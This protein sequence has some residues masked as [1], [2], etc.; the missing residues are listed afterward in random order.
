M[1]IR[2][3]QMAGNAEKKKKT[4]CSHP[5]SGDSPHPFVH[6]SDQTSEHQLRLLTD[7][8]GQQRD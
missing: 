4:G 5:V 8:D 1:D 7:G 3:R 2:S 6:K